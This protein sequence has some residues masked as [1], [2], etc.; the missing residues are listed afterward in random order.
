M[1][2]LPSTSITTPPPAFSTT[3]GTAIPRPA[4]TASLLRET[5]SWDLG[6]GIDVTSFRSCG[7]CGP[8]IDSFYLRC[9]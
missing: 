9:I 6:P 2:E 1:M 5:N 8:C 3:T 7:M 4:E